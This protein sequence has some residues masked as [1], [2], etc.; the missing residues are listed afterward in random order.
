[1]RSTLTVGTRV[2]STI[3][4]RTVLTACGALL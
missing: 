1:M 4:Q 2:A 3:A